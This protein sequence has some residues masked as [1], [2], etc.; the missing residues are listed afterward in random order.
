MPNGVLVIKKTMRKKRENHITWTI[1]QSLERKE[2]KSEE[3]K[4]KKDPPFGSNEV[5]NFGK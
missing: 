2:H 5:E 1:K 4:T 3:R